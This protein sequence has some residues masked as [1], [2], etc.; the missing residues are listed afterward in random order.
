ML[1]LCKEVYSDI[2]PNNRQAKK[3]WEGKG[4]KPPPEGVFYLRDK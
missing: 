1:C 2:Y 4:E 3:T